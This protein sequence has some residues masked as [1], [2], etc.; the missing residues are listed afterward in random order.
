MEMT[1]IENGYE[2]KKKVALFATNFVQFSQTF[3]Y[4]EIRFHKNYKADVFSLYRH[5]TEL[6]PYQNVHSFFPSENVFKKAEGIFCELTTFS[7]TRRKMISEG[8]Y[9]LIHAHFGNG[10]VYAFPYAENLNLPLVVTFHGY[11]V[12][13]LKT[14]RRFNPLFWRYWFLSRKMFKRVDLFLAASDELR[15][16]LVELGA[17]VEKVKTW[18]LGV[19]IPDIKKLPDRN[20]NRIIMV[21][22][23]V[24]KKGFVYA[25]EAFSRVVKNGVDA[26]L[27][28]VGDGPEKNRYLSLIK[29]LGVQERVVLHG[30]KKHSDVLDMILHSDI[31]V[32]PSVVAPNGDRESGILVAKEA[33]ARYL[34]VIGTIHGGIPEIID[35]SV[36]GFLV[37]E[38]DVEALAEKMTVLLRNDELRS[39]MGLSARKKMEK[40][41]SIS[42]RVDV[43]ESYYDAIVEE[44]R[45][46]QD[47]SSKNISIVRDKLSGTKNG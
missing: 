38:K 11:D 42:D 21:G 47:D 17:P 31:L 9:S 45:R 5:N 14:S 43:L 18:R 25:I 35:D 40:E 28:I 10:S 12:P 46:K 6:F 1:N 15:N 32:A 7:S 29:K 2:S 39:K 4:D 36:T 41:Y 3:I 16:M 23:F 24:E 27:D 20:G 26:F 13:V 33:G 22:R 44:H 19:E 34:P 30:V 37:K 8:G